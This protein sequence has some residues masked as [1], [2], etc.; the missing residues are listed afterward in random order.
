MKKLQ[1]I[2]ETLDKIGATILRIRK[3]RPNDNAFVERVHRTDGEEFYL[4]KTQRGEEYRRLHTKSL[5]LEL[6]LQLC[7]SPLR[8]RNGWENTLPKSKRRTTHPKPHYMLLPTS[9]T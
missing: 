3:G 5:P 6:L 8:K 9:H 4:F 2:N 1:T 7:K